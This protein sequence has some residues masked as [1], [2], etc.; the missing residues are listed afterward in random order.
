MTFCGAPSNSQPSDAAL[1]MF[2]I[3]QT[4][5]PKVSTNS[6]RSYQGIRSSGACSVPGKIR[7]VNGSINAIRR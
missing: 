7:K 3:S 6:S 5:A 4:E 2:I 1:R